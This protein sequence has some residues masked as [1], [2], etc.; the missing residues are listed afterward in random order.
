MQ[1]RRHHQALIDLVRHKR[2]R[3]VFFSYCRRP[4]QVLSRQFI[5]YRLLDDIFV[6]QDEITREVIAALQLKLTGQPAR[7]SAVKQTEDTDAYHLYLKGRFY[8]DKRTPDNTQ[9]AL[10]YFR[11]AVEKDPDYA[12]A[13]AGMA[14]C[15]ALLGF[16]PYGTMRPSEAFPRAK[17]AARK[18]LAL[19]PS[20][21][22]AHATLG[23]CALFYDWN[24]AESEHEFR[25]SLELAPE[26]MG[27]RLWFPVLLS[28]IGK[29]EEAI[30]EGRRAIEIDP[31]SVNAVTLFGQALV[32]AR[33]FDEAEIVLKEALELDPNYPT[34]LW[35]LASIHMVHERFSEAVALTEKFAAIF[36][37]P[38][39]EAQKGFM[40]ARAGR[41][42]DAARVLGELEEMAKRTYVSPFC[43]CF[44][45]AGLGDA[46]SFFRMAEA[47][48]E[49]RSGLALL[50]NCAWFD[51]YRSDPRFPEL[52]RK[53]GLPQ[54]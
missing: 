16:T 36:R 46:D 33:R 9:K 13:Y 4:V 17:A 10:D 30:R 39:W 20:Q 11:Q 7:K 14:D 52:I 6:L 49:E 28:L 48:I 38:V 45:H 26:S 22:E 40:W 1:R 51:R 2:F 54:Q 15:Y 5:P 35:F 25:R 44:V 47:S 42:E 3:H 21:G 31:L 19:D 29:P 41:T 27:T 12:P 8:W 32:F 37:H 24:W 43:T 23:V 18:A 50:F 53:V 34:A